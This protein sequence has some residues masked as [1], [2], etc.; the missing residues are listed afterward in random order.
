MKKL[1]IRILVLECFLFINLYT[2]TFANTPL[3]VSFI[4]ISEFSIGG[5]SFQSTLQDVINIYGKPT[6]ITSHENSSY[7]SSGPYMMSQNFITYNYNNKFIIEAYNDGLSWDPKDLFVY[8]VTIKD[9]NNLSTP[10]GFHV[11]QSFSSVT[12]I[13]GYTA[14]LKKSTNRN[15]NY[16]YYCYKYYEATLIFAVDYN[17][18]I[19]EISIWGVTC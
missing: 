11:G 15:N 10:S 3:K 4:P 18:I 5:I 9:A 8:S 13:Y 14:K 17:N 2:I 1:F 19:R 12:N 16:S 7:T 6:S